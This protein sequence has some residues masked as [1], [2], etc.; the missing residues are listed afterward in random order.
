MFI[1]STIE[2]VDTETVMKLHGISRDNLYQIRMR[3]TAKL[4]PLVNVVLKEMDEG[5][6]SD[7]P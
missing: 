7:A 3:L 1:E 6:I 2:G 4:R 5:L